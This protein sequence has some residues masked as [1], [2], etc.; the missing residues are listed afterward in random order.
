[1]HGAGGG[2]VVEAAAEVSSPPPCQRSGHQFNY[3]SIHRQTKPMK[4]ERYDT[5]DADKCKK[6]SQESA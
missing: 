1:M 3:F 5:G 4:M 6:V 2:S